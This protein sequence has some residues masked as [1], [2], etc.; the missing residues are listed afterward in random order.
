MPATVVASG[1]CP[2]HVDCSCVTMVCHVTVDEETC[3]PNSYCTDGSEAEDPW[4][5]EVCVS[6]DNPPEEDPQLKQ[7]SDFCPEG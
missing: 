6:Y 1:S 5:T 2:V 4:C 7:C 3:S